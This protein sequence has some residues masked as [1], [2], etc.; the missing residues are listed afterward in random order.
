MQN[1]ATLITLDELAVVGS[2]AVR[3]WIKHRPAARCRG[4]VVAFS[5]GPHAARS[6]EGEG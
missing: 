3:E 1:I 5:R 6:G 4:I 2:V